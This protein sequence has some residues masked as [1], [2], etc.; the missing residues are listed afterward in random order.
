MKRRGMVLLSILWALLVCT[1]SAHAYLD[2]GSGSML[3]QLLLGGTAGIAVIVKLYYRRFLAF[4]GLKAEQ[5]TEERQDNAGPDT[6][7]AQR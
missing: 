7:V 5:G 1:R 4:L 2:P 3:L 6:N